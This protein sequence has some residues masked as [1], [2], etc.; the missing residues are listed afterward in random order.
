MLS[1]T[2][3]GHSFPSYFLLNKK[4]YFTIACLRSMIQ[5]KHYLWPRRNVKSPTI[6]VILS[7][8]HNHFCSQYSLQVVFYSCFK[9]MFE[10]ST[11][12]FLSKLKINLMFHTS[13]EKE[14]NC[15]GNQNNLYWSFLTL[16]FSLLDSKTDVNCTI[17]AIQQ[18]KKERKG[19]R[20]DLKETDRRRLSL[21]ELLSEPKKRKYETKRD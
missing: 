1:Q 21:L 11:V 3:N 2:F 17:Q 15:S 19:K 13:G 9:F 16:K 10:T 14:L 8:V 18:G 5:T 7:I 6:L 20:K 12:L 4:K